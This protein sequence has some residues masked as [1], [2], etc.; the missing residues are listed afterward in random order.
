MGADRTGELCSERRVDDEHRLALRVLARA[1]AVRLGDR[2][3]RPLPFHD[4]RQLARVDPSGQDGQ[5]GAGR[6]H[7]HAAHVPVIAEPE[8]PAGLGPP[9][10]RPIR[11]APPCW[12]RGAAMTGPV[13]ERDFGSLGKG[14]AVLPD[15]GQWTHPRVQ[16]AP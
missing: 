16:P 9:L 15:R 5:I 13:T 12:A 14:A 2:L 3:Q 1:V 11:R 8:R 6:P 7:Q 4:R 10:V